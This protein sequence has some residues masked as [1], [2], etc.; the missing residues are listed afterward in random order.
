M[1]SKLCRARPKT[2][3]DRRAPEYFLIKE[4]NQMRKSFL[5][6]AVIGMMLSVPAGMLAQDTPPTPTGTPAGPGG[7]GGR[8]G[9]TPS[10][11]PQPYEKVITKDAKSKDG[12]FKVHQIKDKYFYEIP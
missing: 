12:V 5:L 7:P 6:L 2:Q 10:S 3:D 9:A 8:P 4:T 11:D 1:L